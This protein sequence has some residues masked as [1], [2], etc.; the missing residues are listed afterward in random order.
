MVSHP[1]TKTQQQFPL[2]WHSKC[3]KNIKWHF[4][5]QMFK[6]CQLKVSNAQLKVSNA[7]LK[8]SNTQLTVSKVQRSC[9]LKVSKVQRSCKLKVS[10]VQR[11]C[12]LKVSKVQRSTFQYSKPMHWNGD[13]ANNIIIILYTCIFMDRLR[14]SVNFALRITMHELAGQVRAAAAAINCAHAHNYD[15]LMR[16]SRCCLNN[17]LLAP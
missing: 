10:K 9:K 11:S 17:I 5:T 4:Q 8:V 7:Q 2:L 15:S 13:P 1:E 12:K 16:T 14:R 3:D 6:S